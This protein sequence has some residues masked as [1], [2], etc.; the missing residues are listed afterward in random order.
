MTEDERE[1]L[2]SLERKIERLCEIHSE[3]Q[4]GIEKRNKLIDEVLQSNKERNALLD[5]LLKSESED[6]WWKYGGDPEE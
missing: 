2:E 4:E 1:R 3:L 5:D 6:E